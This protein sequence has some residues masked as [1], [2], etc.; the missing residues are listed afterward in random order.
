[1][2]EFLADIHIQGISKL[3]QNHVIYQE[4]V[5]WIVILF[6]FFSLLC[7]YVTIFT[8][9]FLGFTFC[10]AQNKVILPTDQDYFE[11]LNSNDRQILIYADIQVADIVSIRKTYLHLK[12][13]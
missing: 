12:K 6:V 2:V 11:I 3:Y 7:F 1:M 13:A 5:S 9:L 8:I 4:R 10:S